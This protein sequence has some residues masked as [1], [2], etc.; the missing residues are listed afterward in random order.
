MLRESPMKQCKPCITIRDIALILKNNIVYFYRN[1]K[2]DI[3]SYRNM[4]AA[5]C[6]LDKPVK[7][8]TLDE[9]MRTMIRIRE[10]ATAN[11]KE[12]GVI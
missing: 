2:D 8:P 10:K 12:N 1:T 5:V 3:K 7:N 11:Y 6:E 9:Q 4:N